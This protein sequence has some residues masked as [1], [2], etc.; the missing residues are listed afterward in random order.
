VALRKETSVWHLRL[1]Y[2]IELVTGRMDSLEM[3]KPDCA[4]RERPHATLFN[5]LTHPAVT[6]DLHAASV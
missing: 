4:L 6:M 2:R 5:T 1:L 3:T